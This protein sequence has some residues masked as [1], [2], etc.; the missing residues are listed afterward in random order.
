MEYLAWFD[1]FYPSG[2]QS[3]AEAGLY[4]LFL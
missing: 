3:K 2:L 4:P 1:E